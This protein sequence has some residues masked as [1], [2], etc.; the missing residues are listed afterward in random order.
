MGENSGFSVSRKGYNCQEV[1]SYIEIMRET[2]TQ[3]RLSYSDLQEKYDILYNESSKLREDNARMRSDCT[4]LAAALK[5]LREE[6]VNQEDYKAKY[7]A[8]LAEK[9]DCASEEEKEAAQTSAGY[10]ESASKMIAEVAQVVQKLE[11]DAR[12]KADALTVAAKLET[13]KSRLI[14][15]RVNHEVQ[16]LMEMLSGFLEQ[17]GQEPEN[18]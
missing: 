4:T 1:E 5:K 10:S 8:L 2:E 15:Q 3:L 6:A 17:T 14:K 16:S 7:E 18:E 12:R 13:E 11:Q 9:A